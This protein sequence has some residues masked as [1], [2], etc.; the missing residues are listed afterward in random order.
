MDG[1]KDKV[2]IQAALTVPDGAR[3]LHA[4]VCNVHDED[5]PS[6]AV[7]WRFEANLDTL[8]GMR[9]ILR[10]QDAVG[11]LLNESDLTILSTTFLD[12]RNTLR[13]AWK[14]DPQAIENIR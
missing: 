4:E 9:R 1:K 2:L 7:K 5:A 12:F 3:L 8:M 11:I 6:F 13:T 14:D 10:G